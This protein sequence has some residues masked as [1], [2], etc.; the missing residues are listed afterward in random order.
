MSHPLLNIF[1]EHPQHPEVIEKLAKPG[2]SIHWKGITASALA[3]H[4]ASVGLKTD[5][6]QWIILNEQ[7]D[8][9]GVHADLEN[10]LGESEFEFYKKSV[11]FFPSPYKKSGSPL[12]VDNNN[13]LMRTEVLK[14]LSSETRKMIIVSHA[15]ALSDMVVTKGFLQE[16]TFRLKTGEPVD[17]DFVTDFLIEYAFER[18]DFVAEPGQFAIRGGIVDVFSFSNDFPYRIEF[19]GDEIGSI[20]S[21]D[22]VSQLSKD[23]VDHITIVPNLQLRNEAEVRQSVFEFISEKTVIWIQDVKFT[24]ETLVNLLQV[25]SSEEEQRGE[26]EGSGERAVNH[27]DGKHLKSKLQGLRSIEFGSNATIASQDVIISD[28]SPQPSFNKKFDLL[29]RD[30]KQWEEKGYSNYVLSDNPKQIERLQAIFSDISNDDEVLNWRTAMPS[31][32]E[33]FIDHYLKLVCYT[34][35]QIFERYRKSTIQDGYSRRE[36]LTLKELFS[37]QP[38]DYVSHIDHG[39]GRFDGLETIEN[40]GRKQE[41]MRLIYRNNDIVYVSIHALHRIARYTGKEGAVPTLDRLGSGA[42]KRLKEKTKSKVKD[43]ARDLIKLYARR[44]ASKGFAFTPDTYLQHELEASFIFEDTP[45]QIT[46]TADLKQDME[47][48]YPMDRLICGDVGFGKTEVAIR[49][50]FKAVA[51]SKQVA[52]LVP[53]TILALQHYHTF[54]ERLKELPVSV[55]YI[56]RFRSTAHQKE[57]LKR[58]EEGKLDIIIG[59]HRI[60]GKDVKFKDLGLLIIDEEQKFGVSVKEKLKE[61]RVNVDTLTLTA[62]PIPRTLQFS[63]MGARDLSVIST[64]PPNRHP[65]KTELCAFSEDLIR[66]AIQNE[67]SR[68]GQVFFLHNRIQNI[69]DVADMVARIVPGISVAVGHGQ[70]EGQKL[71]KVMM[72]FIEG[73][74]DVLV[75]TSIIESGL[76]IPNANTIIINDAHMYGLSDLHQLRGRVGRSNKKAFCYLITPPLSV[77]TPEARKRLRAIEEFSDLGSGF[78]IAMRDLDIRGAGNILGA[79]QSGFISEIGYEMYQKILKEAM[80]ELRLSEFPEMAEHTP[81]RQWK[82][83]AECQIETDLEILL[84]SEYVESSAER[85]LLYRELDDMQEEDALVTFRKKLAD[86]FGPVPQPAEDLIETIRLRWVAA[87]IGFE[88]IIL[89]KDRFSGYFPENQ[90]HP[91]Y[92]SENFGNV[93]NYVK[94]HPRQCMLREKNGKLNLILNSVKNID[95]ANKALGRMIEE[96]AHRK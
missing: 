78:S 2:A 22:P 79:E 62:T 43:I 10:V 31:L 67:L 42:W 1:Q 87:R 35:H 48:P 14:R 88:K 44:L 47:K 18:V 6:P 84:P 92:Q 65:V 12:M 15:A 82:P 50:A 59:T 55:D 90:M 75:S 74:S 77:L 36:S 56:N 96:F 41:A 60:V 13:V 83:G 8:A 71:E 5:L 54:R 73:N 39:I 93:L 86:R 68:G 69:N 9:V 70:M 23:I 29:K 30:L 3:L 81:E 89:R 32:H 11:I 49:A 72:T 37:L 33:G 76:D 45:D 28:Q 27:I 4:V 26:D 25:N 57:T 52:V 95:E 53:T 16:N 19:F 38:G 94:N 24:S 66:D 51:D 61:I 20:R 17:L 85:L 34:D 64:P 46:A 40:N 58:L 80:E 91:F 63:L 21:F 7:E